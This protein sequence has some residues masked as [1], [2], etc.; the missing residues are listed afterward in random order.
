MNALIFFVFSVVTELEVLDRAGNNLNAFIFFVFSVVTD[1]S[2]RFVVRR[3][4]VLLFC[5]FRVLCRH[6]AFP[7]VLN[8]VGNSLNASIFFAFSV[9][10]EF[11]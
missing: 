9:V 5:C 3:A 10:T 4:R 6:G 11:S 2:L 7:E 8:W 1:L